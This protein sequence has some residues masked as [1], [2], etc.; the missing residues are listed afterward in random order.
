M[1]DENN[2]EGKNPSAPKEQVEDIFS[3]TENAPKP[4]AFK[5]KQSE[6]PS[7]GSPPPETGEKKANMKKIIV[8][9]VIILGIALI[10]FGGYWAFNNFFKTSIDG[11]V[12]VMK[13]DMQEEVE[14]LEENKQEEIVQPDISETKIQE[15]VEPVVVD[16]KDTDQDGLTDEEEIRAGSNI[17]AVDTDDDGLFDREEVKVYRTNPANADTDGDG[18]LDGDEVKS[19]YNPNG[20]GKLFEIK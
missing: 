11:G 9:A 10:A 7:A 16:K 4:E 17:N 12:D 1:F 5:P 14:K 2:K 3:D 8:L 15:T 13:D 6:T 19:G 18:F 20:S